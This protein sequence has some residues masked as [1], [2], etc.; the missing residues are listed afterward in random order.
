M[1][2]TILFAILVSSAITAGLL[3]LRCAI[4]AA[5]M[6]GALAPATAILAY[7]FYL[8]ARAPVGPYFSFVGLGYGAVALAVGVA[9]AVI[10]AI[11]ADKLSAG[12]STSE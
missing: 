5:I 10:T 3:R 7:F 4:W 1:T 9:S 2:L 11:L 6:A 8:E 12:R